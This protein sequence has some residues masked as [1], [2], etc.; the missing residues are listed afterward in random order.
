M[1]ASETSLWKWLRRTVLPSDGH[2]TRIESES[3][4]GFPDVHYTL[5]EF[6][7]QMELKVV[8]HPRAEYPLKR[9]GLRP[10]QINWISENFIAGGWTPIVV[11]WNDEV[12]VYHPQFVK[13]LNLMS[14]EELRSKWSLRFPKRFA[15]DFPRGYG[16][17]IDFLMKKDVPRRASSGV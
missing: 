2:F 7:G 8:R 6:T 3:S 1:A 13:K 11:G 16:P 5:R 4:A 9:N 10:S 12:F 17:L 14:A 15:R